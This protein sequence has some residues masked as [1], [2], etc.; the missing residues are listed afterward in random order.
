MEDNGKKVIGKIFVISAPSGAGKSTLTAKIL[1]EFPQLSYSV[2]HTTRSPRKGEQ[3]GRDY[4]F[5]TTIEFEERI[6]ANQ[7]LEWARVHDH[8]YGTSLDFV[9][10]QIQSGSNLLLEIDVQG[11]RQVKK[12]YQDAVT[13]FIM[14]PSL[15]V[16]EQRLRHRGTDSEAVIQR[17]MKNAEK[18]IAQKDFYQYC[19]V[20]DD[21]NQA[22]NDI[23]DIFRKELL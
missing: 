15:A 18:E 3:D 21:L 8:Y 7:W 19:I 11:A 20:N 10:S 22:E 12:A 4:F 2:S 17:R 5:I 1:K 6:R 23:I 13:L 16:L 14:P 9:M